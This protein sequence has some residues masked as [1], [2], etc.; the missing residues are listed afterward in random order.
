MIW[1]MVTVYQARAKRGREARAFNELRRYLPGPSDSFGAPKMYILGKR[2]LGTSIST[3]LFYV[4]IPTFFTSY[5][6]TNARELF[7]NK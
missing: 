5:I 6:G 1:V 7:K 2:I 4:L 3:Q